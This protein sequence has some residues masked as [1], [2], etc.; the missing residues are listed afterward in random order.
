MATQSRCFPASGRLSYRVQL[1]NWLDAATAR[2]GANPQAVIRSCSVDAVLDTESVHSVIPASIQSVL[3]LEVRHQCTVQHGD[4]RSERVDVTEAVIIQFG[5][6]D[7]VEEVLVFG[8]E[9]RIGRTT[10]AKLA[11]E[12]R[13]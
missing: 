2:Q 11:Y 8:D 6:H 4:G 3:G 5:S 9:V 12:T 10:I 13:D 1:K 7:T